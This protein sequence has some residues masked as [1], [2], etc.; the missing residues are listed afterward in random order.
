MRA[1]QAFRRA[2]TASGSA[3]RGA[4]QRQTF[5]PPVA[6]FDG[7]DPDTTVRQDCRLALI[8]FQA[9]L[10]ESAFVDVSCQVV[11]GRS[12][13][14]VKT[15]VSPEL[16]NSICAYSSRSVNIIPMPPSADGMIPFGR[17][18]MSLNARSA[19]SAA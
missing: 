5:G 19:A 17:T 16:S 2:G 8:L 9:S 3:D 14:Y 6:R 13:P 1:E 4:R 11:A 12:G 7:L 18:F 10:R 15:H